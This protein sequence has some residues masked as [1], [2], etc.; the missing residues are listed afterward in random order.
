MTDEARQDHRLELAATLLLALAAIATAW[1]T[2]QSSVWRG[3][4]SEAQSASIAARVESTRQAAVANRH[5]QVDVALF[6]QWIDAY[7]QN[8]G[9]LASFYRRRFRQEFEPAFNAWIA[10]RPRENPKAP[11][12]PFAMPQYRLAAS[13]QA[14][15]LESQAGE[16]SKQ[17]ARNV[18]RADSYMLAVVLYAIALFFAALSTRLKARDLRIALLAFGYVLFVSATLWLATQ[19]VHF[20]A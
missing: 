18:N 4:Q 6:T 9:E 11:L 15:A 8:E 19:P 20:S 16:F 14:D 5:A 3:K 12:S 7:A 13:T 1:S 10:A 2:Y 17:V